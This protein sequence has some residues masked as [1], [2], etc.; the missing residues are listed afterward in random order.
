MSNANIIYGSGWKTGPV[1]NSTVPSGSLL[2]PGWGRTVGGAGFPTLDCVFPCSATCRWKAQCTVPKYK[3]ER[4]ALKASV[5]SRTPTSSTEDVLQEEG[6]SVSLHPL[7]WQQP[8]EVLALAA[9]SGS[10][11]ALRTR[12]QPQLLLII[13]EV[14]HF[15]SWVSYAGEDVG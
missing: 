7:V 12:Q 2:H 10:T 15:K 13:T 3:P 4:K 1:L 9:S 11:S 6:P 5:S 14:S 8:S